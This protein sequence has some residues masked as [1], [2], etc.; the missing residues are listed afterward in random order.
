[1]LAHHK[2]FVPHVDNYVVLHDLGILDNIA[3]LLYVGKSAIRRQCMSNVGIQGEV[4]DDRWES[5]QLRCSAATYP[6]LYTGKRGGNDSRKA[7]IGV[8]NHRLL[9]LWLGVEV[10]R[11]MRL[12]TLGSEIRSRAT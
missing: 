3:E 1:M 10:G 9:G 7:G 11:K 8:D 6:G 4:N 12:T 2:V 5:S